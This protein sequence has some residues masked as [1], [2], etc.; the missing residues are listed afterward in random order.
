MGHYAHCIAPQCYLEPDIELEPAVHAVNFYDPDQ[1]GRD[2]VEN[3]NIDVMDP[4]W[5]NPAAHKHET[6]K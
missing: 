4:F 2:V 3:I 1:S 6:A 5:M